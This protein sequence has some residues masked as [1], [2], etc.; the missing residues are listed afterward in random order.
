MEPDQQQRKLTEIIE[1]R[2]YIRP[3]DGTSSGSGEVPLNLQSVGQG[4]RGRRASTV[5]LAALLGGLVA[6]LLVSSSGFQ[7]TRAVSPIGWLPESFARKPAAQRSPGVAL[8]VENN[9]TSRSVTQI[10]LERQGYKVLV[11]ASKKQALELVDHNS[12]AIVLIVVPRR[13][14]D[15]ARADHAGRTS[16]D[17]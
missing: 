3:V 4:G 15:N 16:A 12:D 9:P 17:Y 2:V 6:V 1:E 14:F 8:L 13:M 5:I 7:G 10:A 11:A